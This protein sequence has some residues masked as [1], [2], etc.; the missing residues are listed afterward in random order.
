MDEVRR[1]DLTIQDFESKELIHIR[2][3]DNV[4]SKR[5]LAELR[6]YIFNNMNFA[7]ETKEKRIPREDGKDFP[8]YNFLPKTKDPS[9]LLEKYIV[10]LMYHPRYPN[11][12]QHHIEYW[13]RYN[14]ELEWHLDG[15]EVVERNG[16]VFTG[17]IQYPVSSYCFYIHVENLKGGELE[18][19]PF[20]QIELGYRIIDNYYRPPDKAYIMT[21]K[22]KS[23]YLINFRR[24]LYHRVKKP[25]RGQRLCLVWSEWQHWPQGYEKGNHWQPSHIKPNDEST[26][27]LVKQVDWPIK[28]VL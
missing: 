19:C 20:Q 26:G 28:E 10:G 13:L 27:F 11:G 5:D 14:D 17:H 9:N 22:P 8:I 4:L 23:N 3:A 21:V 6:N 15:D 18:V 7:D 2:H 24:P 16:T 1:S 12:R 25:E